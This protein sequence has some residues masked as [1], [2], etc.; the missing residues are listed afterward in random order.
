MGSGLGWPGAVEAQLLTDS[1]SEVLRAFAH[2]DCEAQCLPISGQW[3]CGAGQWASPLC[4]Q[5]RS[6]CVTHPHTPSP[7]GRG[8]AFGL[9]VGPFPFPGVGP[10][11]SIHS[12][13]LPQRGTRGWGNEGEGQ[14]SPC[15]CVM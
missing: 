4:P 1:H 10:P 6:S 7:G 9:S 15:G 11:S 13:F 8:T 2:S 12:P 14:W 5:N 3:G